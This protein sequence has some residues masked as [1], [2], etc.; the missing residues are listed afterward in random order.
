MEKKKIHIAVC[1]DKGYVM[2]TGV[3]MYSICINNQDVD[4]DFHVLI[5]ESVS[6]KERQNLR[7]TLDKFHGKRALFYS[8]RSISALSFPLVNFNHLTRAAYY[9]LFLSDILPATV[10][11]VLYLD[12]DIIVRHSLLLLWNTDLTNHAIGVAIDSN[13]GKI[14]KYYRLRYSYKKGYF[15]SGVLLI[16]LKY[17]RDNHII[18]EFVEYLNKN[19]ERIIHEDQDVMNVVL[20]DKKLS[21]PVKYNFQSGF[22]KKEPGWDYWGY[23]T[24]VNAGMKDPV[25]VHFSQG[26]KPWYKNLRYPHPYAN[27][28]LKYQSQTKW[29]NS[30]YDHRTFR[31]KIRNVIGNILRIIGVKKQVGSPFI[32]IAPID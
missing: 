3:M 13:E 22:L 4:I 20:K 29:K 9:R 19:P 2:P 26:W 32:D 25:I 18:K 28:F 14:E 23:K 11:K 6:E 31:E 7:E 10:E 12:G 17:W 30:N 1:L 16:N 21:I 15:N 24:E 27:T 8:V 5:D